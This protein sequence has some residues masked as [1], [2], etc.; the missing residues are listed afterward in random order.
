MVA[1]QLCTIQMLKDT[2][3]TV[4]KFTVQSSVKR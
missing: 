1:S 3:S 2:E 4:L